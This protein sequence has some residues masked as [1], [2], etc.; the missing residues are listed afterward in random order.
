MSLFNWKQSGATSPPVGPSGGGRRP[1]EARDNQSSF[2]NDSQSTQQFEELSYS[3]TA[4]LGVLLAERNMEPIEASDGYLLAVETLPNFSRNQSTK[5]DTSLVNP[6]VFGELGSTRNTYEGFARDEY[7]PEFNG[8]VGMQKYDKMRRGDAA[9]RSALN[10]LKTPIIGATWFVEPAEETDKHR[11]IALFIEQVFT[12]WMTYSWDMVL[13]E[14]LNML[15]FGFYPFEK[16]WDYHEHKGKRYV[17]LK[18]LAPRHPMHVIDDGFEYDST[19][20]PLGM[21]LYNYPG[22]EGHVYIPIKK[23]LVFTNDLEGGD[24]RGASVLRSAYKHWFFKEQAYK[25]D[26]IQKERHSI[27]IPIIKLPMGFTD[28]DRRLAH[29]I[30]RN[31]RTNERAHVVLPP[32]WEI[33]F[34]KLEGRP[35]S[36][37]ETADHHTRMIYQNVL[38]QGLW[39]A[40][41]K[42]IDTETVM[43]LFY[44][45]TRQIAN[46]VR[47][48]I[49]HYMIPDLVAANWDNVD[50]FPELKVRRLGDTNEARVLSF[51]LRN[52]VGA[53]IIQVDDRLERWAR[54]FIDAPSHDPS[55][56]RELKAL[57]NKGAFGMPKQAPA[58]NKKPGAGGPSTGTD[59]NG[60][61]GGA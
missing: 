37:L 61:S 51:A 54:E 41:S 18:K 48:I 30:G 6:V 42:D 49:N 16:V 12:H 3:D 23:S 19:G 25:I 17:I 4:H 36:A 10:I 35:V 43:E 53:E 46:I 11:K 45:S 2:R 22:A 58:G 31:L 39:V 14:A 50:H 21:H 60:E 1:P 7:N 15:D 56:K 32:M 59:G 29:E 52:L 28:N 20:G 40:G 38:A 47:G 26:G 13:K 55:T 5:L 44:K 57:Q 8:L 34:A 24:L 9:T 33:I 27:G